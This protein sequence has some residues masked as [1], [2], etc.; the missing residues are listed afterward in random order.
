MLAIAGRST[1]APPDRTVRYELRIADRVTLRDASPRQEVVLVLAL[2]IGSRMF[3]VRR[4]YPA[5]CH[6]SVPCT[7]LVAAASRRRKAATTSV[8]MYY[9]RPT[10]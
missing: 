7:A 1:F 10:T 9:L 2:S 6:I 4:L 3:R 5:A 8:Y